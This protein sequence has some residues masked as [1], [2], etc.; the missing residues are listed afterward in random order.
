SRKAH[1][2]KDVRK[3]FIPIMGTV[4]TVFVLIAWANLSTALMLFGT[5]I[6]LLLIG[7]I[8]AKQIGMVCLGGGVLLTLVIFLCPRS[9]TYASRIK[10]FY[11]DETHKSNVPSQKDKN[12]HANDAMIAI[13][14]GIFFGK[15][16]G[17]CVQRNVLPHP[18]SDV[19]IAI[20]IEEYATVGGL[21][22]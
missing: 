8:D 18:Y 5:S 1:E 2:I 12:F 20:A 15:R 3:S 7:R 9:E 4:C 19:I 17:N 13:A 10:G 16:P 6:L 22:L 21:I 14:T 11:T